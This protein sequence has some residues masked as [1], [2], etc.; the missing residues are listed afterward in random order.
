MADRN[1]TP[2]RVDLAG[3]LAA[4]MERDAIAY[5]LIPEPLTQTLSP[6]EELAEILVSLLQPK[7]DDTP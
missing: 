7:A 4:R 1:E 6:N 2:T 5:R 3:D